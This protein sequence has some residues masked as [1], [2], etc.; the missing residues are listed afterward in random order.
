ME[1][2]KAGTVVERLVFHPDY[3]NAD[4][5]GQILPVVD[6]IDKQVTYEFT[7]G[8]FTNILEDAYWNP[9][10]SYVLIIEEINRGNAPA[11]F[12]DVFQLLDRSFEEKTVDGITYPVG[13]S[14]Y[15][16]AGRDG[17]TSQ[18]PQRSEQKETCL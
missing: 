9:Q 1:Y 10:T 16:G 14:E 4:F 15:A 11:I 17:E 12:G 13:T 5:V 3:T 18:S 2:C 7:A 8:P 6:P